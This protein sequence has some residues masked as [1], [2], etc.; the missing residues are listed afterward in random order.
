MSFFR[1]INLVMKALYFG[2]SLL[3]KTISST[4]RSMVKTGDVDVGIVGSVGFGGG[5]WL[6]TASII[7]VRY[8]TLA[9]RLSSFSD[10]SAEGMLLLLFIFNETRSDGSEYNP[11]TFMRKFQENKRKGST[12]N[13]EFHHFIF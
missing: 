1:L 4:S 8:S 10:G 9:S 2:I 6:T 5:I 12:C 7:H 13:Q 11:K 3:P